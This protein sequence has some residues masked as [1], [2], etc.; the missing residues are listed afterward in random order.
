MGTRLPRDFKEFTEV[1]GS[2]KMC[3]YLWVEAPFPV[4][5]GYPKDLLRIAAA[6]YDGVVGGRANIPF[7][8]FP[9]PGG[10]LPA[11]RTDSADVISWITEGDPDEWGIF[12]WSWPGL[13]AVTM[14]DMNLSAFLVDL[15]SMRSPLFPEFFPE[16]FFS[17]EQRRLIVSD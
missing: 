6:E 17:P 10:L 2:V 9:E 16:T 7:L 4:R 8:E 3:N 11:A 13:K 14:K 12:L 5:D 15:V 1:Y